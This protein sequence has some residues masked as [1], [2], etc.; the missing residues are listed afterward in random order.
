MADNQWSKYLTKGLPYS[1]D[2]PPQRQDFRDLSDEQKYLYIEG[3]KRFQDPHIAKPSDPLSFYQIAC[4]HGL[5]Y[6]TWPDEEWNTSIQ[7]R[8]LEDGAFGGFCT[9]SSILFLT[10]HRPYL[11]LYEAQL[12]GHVKAIADGIDDNDPNKQ[13]YQ[14]L[15]GKFRIP[16]WDWA[17]LDT[18]IVPEE[19]LEPNFRWAGPVSSASSRINYNPLYSYTFPR[20]TDGTVT[21][22]DKNDKKYTHTVR[23][24]D[25]QN[26]NDNILHKMTE[27]Y[28]HPGKEIAV[29]LIPERNLTERTAYILQAYQTYNAMSNDAYRKGAA[30]AE[31]AELWGSLEDIHNAIHNLVGGTGKPDDDNAFIGHMASVPNSAFEPLFW[32]HHANIDRLF[33][34]WQALHEDDLKDYTFV[35]EHGAGWGD[36]VVA[37]KDPENK[38]SPLYPF[39]P[40]VDKWYSS[41]DVKKTEKFGYTYPE[42]AGLSYPTTD[43][44]KSV[45][46]EKISQTYESPPKLIQ[47]SKQGI[48]TAGQNLLA[49]AQ[50]LRDLEAQKVPA[51]VKEQDSLVSQLPDQE[52]LVKRSLGPTKPYLRDLAPDNKFLEWIINVKA[53]KHVLD[54][55]YTVHFFLGPQ[56]E[57][58][59]ALW[60]AT[61]THVGTFAPLG[62]RSTTNCKKCRAAQADAT[63]VTGQVPL[64][65]AL[66]ERYIA[67]IV[68][69]LTPAKV[70]P[71][72]TKNLH[73]RVALNNGTILQDRSQV[74]DLTVFVVTNEV[75]LPEDPSALPIYAPDVNIYPEITDGRGEGTGLT[76]GDLGQ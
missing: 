7:G 68:D 59:V 65:L 16:Y 64:T 49:Q 42:T 19:C 58:R 12:Q 10:W 46:Y 36:F 69:D 21:M 38:H 6:T 44:Q 34:I 31:D 32:L 73:W 54:G 4:I 23:Y 71:Y 75:T 30:K 15:A 11:A 51:T 62:Q 29:P 63:Q 13:Q 61:P 55:N 74:T 41:D 35:L 66:M 47:D 57:Q 52:T 17:R 24:P 2:I 28:E 25:P 60:P 27:F 48:E 14:A 1:G 37:P 67:G 40:E 9:H 39:R 72:L 56:D 43:H 5:P 26:P 22:L 50:L 18:Q 53:A 20:G 8:P 45:L 33:D 70:V 3:L 76:A